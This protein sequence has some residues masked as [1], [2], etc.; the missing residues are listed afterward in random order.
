MANIHVPRGWEV[1]ESLATPEAAYLNRRDFVRRMGGGALLASAVLGACRP[2]RGQAMA[3]ERGPLENVAETPTADLYPDATPDARFEPG[4]RHGKISEER[5]VASYNN[6]YEF[7]TEKEA[8]W[9]NVNRYEPRP[10]SIEVTGLVERP[11]R[12]DLVDLERRFQLQERVYRLR[13][14]EAWS[15]VVPWIGFPL[16]ELLDYLGPRSD[17]RYVRFVSFLR[18]EEAPGQK[19]QTW[20][21]WPYYEAL[22]IDEA[23]NE[24]ALVVTGMYGHPLQKQNGAPVRI[25]VPWKY[26]YKS[27]KAIERIEFTEE[28]PATFWN[29]LAPA[30]YGFLSN[31]NPEVPHPRWSQATERIVETGERIP[32]LPF[33]GYGEWVAEMYG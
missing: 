28:R 3:Q 14:V 25:A 10:W 1:P 8:V 26:G 9:R 18:L 32:T 23:R 13:C 30:E 33:N 21:P 6:F 22:R 19:T 11:G 2:E 15:V 24:L 5:V 31:V 7:G 29:D 17:A 20:Y 4:P 12:Y 27:A 16:R